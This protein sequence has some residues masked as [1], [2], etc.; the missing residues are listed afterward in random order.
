MALALCQAK[1]LSWIQVPLEV[2]TG[3]PANHQPQS[4][5]PGRS[6]C[7]HL[8]DNIAACRVYFQMLMIQLPCLHWL[9]P[10]HVL[11]HQFGPDLIVDIAASL[12]NGHNI[13]CDL[14]G[15]NA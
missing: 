5:K 6:A 13:L 9:W 2:P 7:V 11:C 4:G 8:H 1:W 10:N 3:C 12:L 14:A 15:Y